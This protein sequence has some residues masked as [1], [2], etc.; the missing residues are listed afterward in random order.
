MI[1]KLFFPLT[2]VSFLFTSL[3][4]GQLNINNAQFTIQAGA[5]VTVQ[6]NL[7]SNVD[8]LGTGKILMSNTIAQTIN[9]NGKTIP[10][11][12]I[13][14]AANVTLAGAL[15]IN[16][17]LKFTLGKIIIG[18]Y[19]LTLSALAKTGGQQ[20][21]RFVETNG[22]GQLLKT[23]T[24]NVS[25]LELPVG[26]GTLYRPAF[27]TSTGT[28]ITANVGVRVESIASPVRPSKTSDYLIT[29]WPITKTGITGTVTVTG[30]YNTADITGTETNLRGYF[31]NGTDWSS[32]GETHDVASNRVTAP[33]TTVSGDL[34]GM[35]KFVLVKAKA[36]LQGAYNSTTGLMTDG[37]RTPT[38]MI[39]LSD[40]YRVAPY[41]T[42]FTHVANTVPEVANA[43]VFADKPLANDNI[44]D[45]VFLELRTNGTNPGNVILQTRSALLKRDGNIVDVDGINP[46][47]FNNV[48]NGNYTVAV[49][50]RN[51]LGLSADPVANLLAV[52]EQK[53]T[54][55][56][57]DFTTATDA[58]LY[59]T[60]A[61]YTVSGGKNL[62]WSG[63]VNFNTQT[64]YTGPGN[65]KDYLLA[66]V[67]GGVS[68]TIVNTYSQG[69]LNF[70]RNA[71]Y[72]GPAN[73][74]DFLL[75][76]SL[77]GVSTNI[78]TQQLPQ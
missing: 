56:L 15:K 27:I 32:V 13:Q 54:V 26:A 50:H 68:T 71:K 61:A 1:K 31:Y 10:K 77:G 29:H 76:T 43:S 78:R 63:N 39:P 44:V 60:T 55:P 24:T 9:M 36:F 41:N 69:D 23:L 19:N 75:A 25:L 40:P 21:G 22:T 73:D 49:R 42:A 3:S 62:L 57:L 28:Y 72:T 17:S 16:D 70:N 59:G 66:T 46:V 30:Q 53:S 65:D 74:K 64:K 37:L 20:D 18:N 48:L 35:D 2:V 45:W 33:V 38:N 52:T 4:Y 7:T 34:Y 51:H 58:K 12:E 47:T 8:I 14:N 6:G 5:T 67:L 11:L